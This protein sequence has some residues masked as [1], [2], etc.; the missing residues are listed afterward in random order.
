MPEKYHAITYG[1]GRFWIEPVSGVVVD[2][3]DSGVSYFF[4]P[5]TGQRVGET[6]DQWNKRYTP[7]T[8]KAQLQLATTTRRWM[9]VQKVWLPLTFATAGL[10]WI[11]VGFYI[12]RRGTR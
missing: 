10:I 8:T 12:L 11:A 2:H 7:E 4:E 9:L 3:E 6:I 1:K 5:K